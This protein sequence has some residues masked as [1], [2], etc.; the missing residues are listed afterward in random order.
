VEE[1]GDEE[2][3]WDRIVEVVAGPPRNRRHPLSSLDIL[4]SRFLHYGSCEGIAEHRDIPLGEEEV[5]DE[6]EGQA[7]CHV[8]DETL[9][10]DDVTHVYRPR[11]RY[12]LP[13]SL[14]TA[15]SVFLPY[16]S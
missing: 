8:D 9:H 3:R 7:F 13:S 1:V 4:S 2:R 11:N 6:P 12:S 16:G 5:H 14:G 15:A 10:L